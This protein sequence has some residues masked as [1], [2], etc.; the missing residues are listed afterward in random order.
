MKMLWRIAWPC[1]AAAAVLALANVAMVK[2]VGVNAWT[3]PLHLAALWL[4]F[5][6]AVYGWMRLT[7]G[8]SGDGDTPKT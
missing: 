5:P 2:T 8:K 7:R 1:F 3:V 4:M 6:A